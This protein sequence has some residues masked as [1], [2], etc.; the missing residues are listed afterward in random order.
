[1]EDPSSQNQLDLLFIDGSFKIEAGEDFDQKELE[2]V[3]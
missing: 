2:I 1:M 3:I